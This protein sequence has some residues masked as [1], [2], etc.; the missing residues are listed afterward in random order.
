MRIWRT[1]GSEKENINNFATEDIG[2][3]VAFAQLPQ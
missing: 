1:E 3:F 2:S